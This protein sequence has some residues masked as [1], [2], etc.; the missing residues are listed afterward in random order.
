MFYFFPQFSTFG[1][2]SSTKLTKVDEKKNLNSENN[3]VLVF[4]NF[5]N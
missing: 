3:N 1:R 4:N 5:D 2:F